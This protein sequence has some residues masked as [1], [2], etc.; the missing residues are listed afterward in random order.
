MIRCTIYRMKEE[1]QIYREWFLKKNPKIGKS[2]KRSYIVDMIRRPPNLFKRATS[3]CALTHSSHRHFTADC[4]ST[5][6]PKVATLSNISRSEFKFK[7]LRDQHSVL[8]LHAGS[9]SNVCLRS[10]FMGLTIACPTKL[11]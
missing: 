2:R 11:K 6:S 4:Y 3:N 9:F 5:V 10:N 1:R 8:H 7:T